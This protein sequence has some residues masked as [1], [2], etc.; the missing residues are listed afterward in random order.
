MED[1]GKE[2]ETDITLNF[3][4]EL[5]PADPETELE[6]YQALCTAN[7]FKLIEEIQK[8]LGEITS[9]YE[10]LSPVLQKKY[11]LN[12]LESLLN[13]TKDIREIVIKINTTSDLDKLKHLYLDWCPKVFETLNFLLRE[14]EKDYQILT[15]PVT[16]EKKVIEFKSIGGSANALQELKK[17]S[18]RPGI[19]QIRMPK[20]L[21]ETQT[22]SIGD[23]GNLLG[24]IKDPNMREHIKSLQKNNKLLAGTMEGLSGGTAY[25]KSF[26]IVLARTLNEQSKYYKTEEDNSGVPMSLV[27]ELFTGNVELREDS[28]TFEGRERVGGKEDKRI[29]PRILVSYEDL[30]SKMRGK[31][32]KRGGKDAVQ[33]R[34]YIESLSGKEYFLSGGGNLI[35][36]RIFTKLVSFYR[37]ETGDEIGCFLMLSP[38]FSKTLRGYTG[39]RADTIQLIGGGRQKDITMN[40]LGLLLFVRGTDKGNTWKKKKKDLLDQIGGG[41]TYSGR[42][43]KREEHF[44]EAIQKV[45]DSYLITDYR[46]EKNSSGETISVFVFNPDYSKGKEAPEIQTGE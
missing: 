24:D 41:K 1:K 15:D 31:G 23:I 21:M 11:N 42:P 33:I 36:I 6:L 22:H 25:L 30:A 13:E 43:G 14:K 29:Y 26:I 20:D 5:F 38:Q 40:L 34:D 12:D 35:G 10:Q 4:G 39:L 45:K 9:I 46:E 2:K 37:P 44:K 27:R 28:V 17:L 3:Q 16:G 8:L 19:S 7:V 18:Q 32:K